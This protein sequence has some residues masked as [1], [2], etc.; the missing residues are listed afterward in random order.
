MTA[1]HNLQKILLFVS[2]SGKP[3]VCKKQVCCAKEQYIMHKIQL[4]ANKKRQIC[5]LY[6]GWDDQ[7]DGRCDGKPYYCYDDGKGSK[8]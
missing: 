2:L 3:R 1:R 7:Y 8:L 4:H 6:S 5:H